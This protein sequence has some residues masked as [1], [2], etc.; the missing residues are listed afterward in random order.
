MNEKGNRMKERI[1]VGNQ[2]QKK[3]W[4]NKIGRIEKS[5]KKERKIRM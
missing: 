5:G 2:Y 4:K 1:L 3:G